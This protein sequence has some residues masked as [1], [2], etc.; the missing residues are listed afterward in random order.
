[1]ER[2]TLI[3]KDLFGWIDTNKSFTE[4]SDAIKK[5]LETIGFDAKSIAVELEELFR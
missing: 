1:M 5:A 3:V 2:R 4:I